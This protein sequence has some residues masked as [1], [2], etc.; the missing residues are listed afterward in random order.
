MVPIG[1]KMPFQ[2]DIS[3]FVFMKPAK[4]KSRET[5]YWAIL[6]ERSAA[7]GDIGTVLSTLPSQRQAARLKNNVLEVI[8][9]LKQG[10]VPKYAFPPSVNVDQLVEIAKRG[11]FHLRVVQLTKY[12]DPGETVNPLLHLASSGHAAGYLRCH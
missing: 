4:T 12:L 6:D 1:S 10:S 8:R 11:V 9:L 5:E 7:N 3:L 2:G